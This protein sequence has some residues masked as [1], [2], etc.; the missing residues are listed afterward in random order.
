MPA[1]I[2]TMFYA[3]ET[4]WHGYGTYVGDEPVT[5]D[6]ALVASGL[7]WT[8]EKTRL[9]TA[10]GPKS[11]GGRLV[12]VPDNFAVTRSSD[13]KVLG[14]VGKSFKILQ[15]K[16]AFALLD[17]LVESGEVR[18]HTAGAL[19]GGR[20]AWLLA[21]VGSFEVVP[22]DQVDKFLALF[23]AFDGSLMLRIIDT[24]VR[25]VC[26][27]TAQAAL[28]QARGQGIAV[29]H[30]RHMENRVREAREVLE[31]VRGTM[32]KEQELFQTM[33]KIRFS[34]AAFDQ[35]ALHLVPDPEGENVV[36]T[37]AKN[38]REKLA[39]LFEAGTGQDIP[40]V[41]GTAWAAYNAVTEYANYHRPTR[42]DDEQA[43]RFES[44]MFGAS[45][46]MILA[47][48]DYLTGVVQA[49]A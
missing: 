5:S 7:D 24:D 9:F 35:F 8:A 3:G 1:D 19:K 32:A 49:S 2:E 29:K 46:K 14:V 18:Y 30:T 26:S 34:D 38:Q 47:A 22:G 6:V 20:L 33:A 28:S 15:N 16:D 41:R 11:E 12:E 23:N 10:T 17:S 37:K 13:S 43:K 44:T 36:T 25:V 48:Q 39:E 45:K 21:K 42:G 40:G 4:P 27:N 31:T